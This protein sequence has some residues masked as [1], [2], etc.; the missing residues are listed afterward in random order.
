MKQ[1][2]L[3]ITY[4]T[5]AF[6]LPACSDTPSAFVDVEPA[7]SVLSGAVQATQDFGLLARSTPKPSF[8]IPQA[9]EL[10]P[11]AWAAPQ[12]CPAVNGS[13]PTTSYCDNETLVLFYDHCQNTSFGE[14]GLWRMYVRLEFPTNADCTAVQTSGFTPAVVSSLVGKTVTRTYGMGPGGDQSNVRFAPS[15]AQ[16]VYLY[17]DYP[18]GWKEDRSGGVQITF[19]S[20]TERKLEV[21]GVQVR[22]A[23]H[24]GYSENVDTET[25]DLVALASPE[26][27]SKARFIWDHTLNTV[28]T[29]DSLFEIGP[30]LSGTA[31]NPSFADEMSSG[32]T[33]PFDGYIIVSGNRVKKGA[34]IRAQHNIAGGIG[35]MLVTE[36]LVWSDPNCCWPTTG[37]IRG[38][39]DRN[40]S[41]STLTETL[42]FTGDRCG[43]IEYVTITGTSDV[44]QLY[45]CF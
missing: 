45:H 11:K 19:T 3:L 17:S 31:D 14:S 32:T 24:P 41:S 8:S 30:P 25:L 27:T 22:S 5:L 28:K 2:R 37:T 38:E 16:A 34:T 29:G 18:S 6:W 7:L 40:F 36:D 4:F 26:L 42:R 35:L 39:S 23:I 21:K 44:N 13:D 15:L 43:S 1:A 20:S 10:F 12:S 33:A 9:F